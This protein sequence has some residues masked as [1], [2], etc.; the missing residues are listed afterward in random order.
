MCNSVGTAERL[1]SDCPT[2]PPDVAV[3]TKKELLVSLMTSRVEI[4]L[5]A[6]LVSL[7]QCEISAESLA[8]QFVISGF[9]YEVTENVALLGYYEA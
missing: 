6:C 8:D 7:P 3:G 1:C 2:V 4:S 5:S 9:R